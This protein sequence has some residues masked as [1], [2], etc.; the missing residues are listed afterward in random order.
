M[1]F[2]YS[3]ATKDLREVISVKIGMLMEDNH[4]LEEN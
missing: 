3:P 2:K 1:L 4:N